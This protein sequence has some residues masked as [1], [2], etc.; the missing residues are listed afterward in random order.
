V[1]VDRVRGFR[2]QVADRIV[3]DGGEVDDSVESLQIAGINVA[4]VTRACSYP[5]GCGPKSQPSY[6][7]TSKPD[8]LVPDG[9]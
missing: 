4:D 6:R 8:N 2:I 3:R 5:P 1:S 9:L 7:P